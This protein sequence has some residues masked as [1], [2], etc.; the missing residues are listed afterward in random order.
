MVSGS[1]LVYL[2]Y[3][4]VLRGILWYLVVSLMVSGESVGISW[5]LMVSGGI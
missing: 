3:L 2:V 1:L 4:V 5:Y